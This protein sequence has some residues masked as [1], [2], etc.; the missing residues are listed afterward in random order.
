MAKTKIGKPG[1]SRLRQALFGSALA[2][3]LVTV[4]VWAAKEFWGIDIPAH[5]ASALTT[6]GTVIGVVIEEL[7]AI[8]VAII[9]VWH[10][11]PRPI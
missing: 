7:V 6:I 2:G 9:K 10:P 5:V 8:I 3:A 11:R 4:G 1:K